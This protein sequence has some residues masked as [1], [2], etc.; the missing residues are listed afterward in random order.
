[1]TCTIRTPFHSPLL[2]AAISLAFVVPTA[3][4]AAPPPRDDTYDQFIV[5]F[6]DGTP[7][8]A[9]A[10]LEARQRML[11]GVAHRR[12]LKLDSVRRG[13]L[14][15]DVV[16]VDR[17][18]GPDEIKAFVRE[19]R[20][21]G[22]I[23]SA[24]PDL[25]VYPT[26]LPNDPSYAS[27]QW[28][29]WEATG[30]INAPA[31]WDLATGTGQKVA[32]LDTG[33]TSHS[34]LN[35]NIVGGYDFIT[36]ITTANDGNGRDA[37]PSD[38]GDWVASNEC[39]NGNS[40]QN[41]SWHGTHVAGTIAAVTH[42]NIGVAGVAFGGKV[43]PIRVLG[44][45]G[46]VTSDIDAAI[47]W[48]SGGAVGGVPANA[49]PAKVINMSLG[50]GG[51]CLP[52]TQAAIDA[53]NANGAIVIVA[54]GNSNADA[55]G[56]QPA[57]CLNVVTVG[58]HGRNGARADYSNYGSAVD[59]SGPGGNAGDILSTLNSGTSAPS[60]ESYAG[61][62]GTSMATPHVA[63]VAALAHQK[64][65][66]ALT[67]AQMETLL[68]LTTRSRP[69]PCTLGCGTGLL[70]ANAAVT[71]ANTTLLTITDA[72]DVVEGNSGT[73]TVTFTVNLTKAAA[74]T[75]TFDI[76]TA[77]GNAS[78][79][80]DYVAK[81]STAQ[82]IAAGATSKTF[83][84]TVNGDTAGEFDEYFLVN[85]TNVV[86]A[87][88]L[89]TQARHWI[90]SDEAP[91]LA[92]GVPWINLSGALASQTFWEMQVPAG[93]TNLVISTSGG[94]GDADLYVRFGAKPTTSTFDCRPFVDGNAETCTFPTPSAGTYHVMLNAF[95]AY[96][97][98]TLTGSYTAAT[99]EL[100][101][102]DIK[103]AESNSGTR[104][105]TF[106]VSLDQPSASPVSF[107]IATANGTAKAGTD[108]VA[109]TALGQVIPAGSVTKT[110]VVV[111]NGDAEVEPNETLYANVTNVVGAEVMDAQGRSTIL[112]DDGPYMYV[113][114]V[115]T[116]EGNSG[117]K[118]ITFTVR[119][120]QAAGVPVTYTATTSDASA[121]AGSDYVAKTLS[122]ETIAAGATSRTFTVTVNGD[123]AKEGNEVIRLTLSNVVGASL[124]DDI[125][126]G[127]I[128]NDDGPNLRVNDVAIS[129]GNSG[130]KTMTFTVSTPVAHTAPITFDIATS[131]GTATV[132]NAD[133]VAKA[134]A[135]QTIATGLL[136]KTF[137]VTLN[138]D[139]AIEANETLK[140]TISNAAGAS[141][142]DAVGVGTITNDD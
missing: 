138:G 63:G 132:A 8:R 87:T 111:F 119:L 118:L 107:D 64:S 80:S 34:D 113:T 32:V 40:A 86:G 55:S 82:S 100:R 109:K 72:S 103:V 5:R 133:Y 18:L 61:Y 53:A 127:S 54:A 38:P 21:D 59:L 27:N 102:G 20:R 92:N 48:A 14:D 75:V 117:T 114:D 35:A 142:Y 85:V 39:G 2:A 36:S 110:F 68:K 60:T 62:Q 50:G 44:K 89:E 41:S 45:C 49:N 91:Q 13:A 51:G 17:R 71:A 135:G 74:G 42:N 93:A 95:A 46:G 1:V 73:H 12:G 10:N 84:V 121:T 112:N 116:P 25:R 9:Q 122:G 83:T 141:I 115:A 98:V 11:A 139:V 16:R 67:A 28:H 90:V 104:N 52:S 140:A 99:P 130:T 108:Y 43:V 81:T 77:N 56:F 7:E 101:I 134:L 94:T 69:V 26:F 105:M 88:A 136:T 106:T 131:D 58:A 33:I 31:A 47:L 120:S 57:S 125:A 22:R 66:G 70:D 15:F 24:D 6:R 126:G 79:G 128:T 96:S 124:Y 78:A 19:L 97:G 23:E 65:S 137:T 3:A 129:E 29:Y 37:D 30:G 76:A 123:T 4:A